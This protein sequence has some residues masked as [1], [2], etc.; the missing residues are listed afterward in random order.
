M[1]IRSQAAADHFGLKIYV[2]TSFKDKYVVVIEPAQ[3][4]S[5]RLLYLSF[6]SEFHYNSLYF[7]ED[8]HLISKSTPRV[9][10]SKVLGKLLK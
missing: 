2:I 5:P 7:Q 4:Q 10:G 3:K 9:L 6:W 1:N 8:A